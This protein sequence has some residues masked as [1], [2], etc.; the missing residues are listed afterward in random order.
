[1]NEETNARKLAAVFS[2]ERVDVTILAQHSSRLFTHSMMKRLHQYLRWHTHIA[3]GRVS[4]VHPITLDEL[5][6]DG[7]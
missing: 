3:A 2:D 5:D 4:E 1:M 7:V 6:N